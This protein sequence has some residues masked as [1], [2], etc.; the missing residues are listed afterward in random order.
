VQSLT[1]PD[2]RRR[3]GASLA[4]SEIRVSHAE[5]STGSLQH[6][7]SVSPFAK[8]QRH[9][10]KLDR[11]LLDTS[12]DLDQ[13]HEDWR[14]ERR[15]LLKV[16]R[17]AGLDVD[18]RGL[19]G[20]LNSSTTPQGDSA[21]E[22]TSLRTQLQDSRAQLQDAH[23]EMSRLKSDFAKKTEEHYHMFTEIGADYTKQIE[24]LHDEL[25]RSKGEVTRLQ[26]QLDM[27]RP[28][29]AVQEDELRK[30]ISILGG[31]LARAQDDAQV[32]A[33]ALA[34]A[35]ARLS[36]AH[37]NEQA[38][39]EQLQEA[40]EHAEMLQSQLDSAEHEATLGTRRAEDLQ[41]QLAASEER[42]CVLQSQLD[43][44]RR[45]R[46]LAS[47]DTEDLQKRLAAAESRAEIRTEHTSSLEARLA[48]A[49]DR[50]AEHALESASLE[51][52]LSSLQQEND[53]LQAEK[54][55]MSQQINSLERNQSDDQDVISD[56]RKIV[57]ELEDEIA[58]SNVEIKANKKRIDE[59]EKFLSAAQATQA[60]SQAELESLKNQLEIA[61]LDATE[62]DETTDAAAASSPNVAAVYEEQLD[63][64]YRHIGRLKAELEGMP[65]RH[66]TLEDR[67][68]RI[69]ALETEKEAL[70]ERLKSR[71]VASPAR[72]AN[73]MRGST[74]VL[75][76]AVSALR[77]PRTPGPLKDVSSGWQQRRVL[78]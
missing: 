36:E 16:I 23:D 24:S 3:R 28:S 22:V 64:A 52:R 34:N 78:R 46:S 37:A 27:L 9:L 71:E 40:E 73:S 72:W 8:I 38:T 56:Q 74:P 11:Q 20:E 5:T 44:A 58:T 15:H 62:V 31:D 18:K 67:D 30:Q 33:E 55:A 14:E 45:D 49:E 43:A 59:L 69:R 47:N 2:G 70:L 19:V 65:A 61:K 21:L 50:I 51:G 10:N 48:A 60:S 35:Q 32:V 57:Q 76:K 42:A 63:E 68:A 66:K 25:G 75:H 13:E 26:T 1:S 7:D 17:D 12:S 77:S 6:L 54:D 41:S 4:A 29:S 39:L 53:S